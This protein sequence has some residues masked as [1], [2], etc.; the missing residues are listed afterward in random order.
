MEEEAAKCEA[1]SE[2]SSHEDFDFGK[3]EDVG[4]EI[5]I[6]VRLQSNNRVREGSQLRLM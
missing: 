4:K 3:D 6:L 1:G 5:D 2:A